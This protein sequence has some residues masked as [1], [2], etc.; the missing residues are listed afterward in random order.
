M[1]EIKTEGAETLQESSMVQD[2]SE[3]TWLSKVAM[4]NFDIHRPSPT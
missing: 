3:N 1:L 2:L 4:K